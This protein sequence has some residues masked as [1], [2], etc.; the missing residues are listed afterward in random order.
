LISEA[1]A[2]KMQV[3]RIRID[4]PQTGIPFS[5]TNPYLATF[6]DDEGNEMVFVRPVGVAAGT[7]GS[8]FV[9]DEGLGRV[10]QFDAQGN[11]IAV[12]NSEASGGPQ[13][14]RDAVSIDTYNPPGARASIYVLDPVRGLVH[15]W[16]PK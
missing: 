2:E 8:V 4:R 6:T 7:D 12:V 1:H 5:A 11:S 16:E 9:L 14:L 13:D 15:R 10:F 3:Q